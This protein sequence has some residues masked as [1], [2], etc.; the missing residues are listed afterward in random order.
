MILECSGTKEANYEA[1]TQRKT[2]NKYE[3]LGVEL[4]GYYRITKGFDV[5][6]GL[7]YTHAEIKNALDATIVGNTPRRTPKFMYSV[8]PNF[9]IEKLHVGF[10]LIGATKAYTQDS[11]KL[12]MPGYAI[13]NPY[14]SYPL[15]KNLSVSVNA[16]NIFN[17]IAV[18]EAEEGS[19][20]GGNGIVRAR[21]LPGSS[22][23]ASVKFDF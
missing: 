21:T 8:N 3:S 2:E 12:I 20:A 14:V 5:K 22:C 23:S 16:N 11:N 4:D 17:T 13:V 18:T 7:T 9:S 19:I 10:Y 1:T 15:M 6:A